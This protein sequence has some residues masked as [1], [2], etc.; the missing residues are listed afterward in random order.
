VAQDTY[1]R[2][3]S[4]I[5]HLP[6]WLQLGRFLAVGA[7]GFVINLAIYTALVHGAHLGYVLSAVISNAVALAS[8]FFW[9]RL[10]TFRATHGRRRVQAPRFLLVYVV[11]FATNLLVLRVGV[12]D[13]GIAR[14]P[15]E[16]LASAVAAPVNFLGSRQWAFRGR[17]EGPA[18]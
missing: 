17:P 14:V 16:V 1:R 11:G 12:E 15:A 9:N 7:I 8:N 4:A 13:L 10:W 2:Y 3:R 18:G 6:N 5:A